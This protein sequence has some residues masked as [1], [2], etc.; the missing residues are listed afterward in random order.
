MTERL[1]DDLLHG[2][3]Q[4]ARFTGL[5]VRAVYAYAEKGHLPSFKV[6]GT[7]CARKSEIERGLSAQPRQPSERK[8]VAIQFRAEES[9]VARL[10]E[11]R[12]AQSDSPSRAEA[13]RQLMTNSLA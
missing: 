9:L 1:A 6:G 12:A 10:D 3:Q 8:S 7:L 13:V 11:W 2:A 5:P 4:I